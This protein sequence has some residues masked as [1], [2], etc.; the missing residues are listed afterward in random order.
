[1]D[2]PGGVLA[3]QLGPCKVLLIQAS[4]GSMVA[5]AACVACVL[6]ACWFCVVRVFPKPQRTTVFDP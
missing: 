2:I 3:K 1:M 6:H 4:W 5:V